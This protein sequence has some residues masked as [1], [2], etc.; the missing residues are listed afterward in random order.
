MKIILA[1]IPG[2]GKT[3]IVSELKDF[4]ELNVGDFMFE[5]AKE[6]KLAETRDD[7]RKNINH[8]DYNKIQEMAVTKISELTKDKD[9]IINTH[10]SI[11][12]QYGF[13]QGLPDFALEKLKPNMFVLVEADPKEILERR[14]DPTRN[15]DEEE[16]FEIDTHQKMN[17]YFA[18]IYS[19]KTNASIKIIH[20]KQDRLEEAREELKKA[21]DSLK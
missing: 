10:L 5:A 20:N 2:S 4:Q 3:A 17:R 8:E 19:N 16:E 6:L 15:R 14:K 9:S 21:V 7:L 11:K 12:H 18:S 13:T 1:G